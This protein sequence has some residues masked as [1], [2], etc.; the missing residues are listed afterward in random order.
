MSEVI[1]KPLKRVLI[2]RKLAFAIGIVGAAALIGVMAW[3]EKS[4][5]ESK[6]TN[7]YFGPT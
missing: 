7:G 5:N 6:A 2:S 1:A 4:H 3:S